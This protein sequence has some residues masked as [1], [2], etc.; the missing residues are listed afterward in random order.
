[1]EYLFVPVLKRILELNL[2]RNPAIKRVDFD[3]NVET[4][5]FDEDPNKELRK[6]SG[7]IKKDSLDCYFDYGIDVG[8]ITPR[9]LAGR[10]E[11]EGDFE[12]RIESEYS[13]RRFPRSPVSSR[14]VFNGGIEVAEDLVYEDL[15]CDIL[16]AQGIVGPDFLN[17][18]FRLKVVETKRATPERIHGHILL[19][20]NN[21]HPFEFT[22]KFS[23][24]RKKHYLVER[25][26]GKIKYE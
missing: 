22:S 14:F 19:N 6:I 16:G 18:D 12:L 21:Q 20:G 4:K 11:K 17:I 24:S 23:Q 26:S 2:E 13:S 9:R 15:D 10:I 1:M 8:F 7:K 25:I 5:E 3:L